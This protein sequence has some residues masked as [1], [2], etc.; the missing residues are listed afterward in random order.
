[1][2]TTRQDFETF[3]AEFLRWQALF[4]LTD[5]RITF[6]HEKVDGCFADIHVGEHVATVRLSSYLPNDKPTL[7]DHDPKKH[8]RHEAIHLL[9]WK[10]YRLA[11]SRH[12]TVSDLEEEWEALT[13]RVEY[14]LDH[15]DE[16]AGKE[17]SV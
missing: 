3:K 12:V 16:T 17:R 7:A 11:G 9:T 5:F 4:G 14:A 6:V 15:M 1:M 10:L 8:A 13:R 2:K